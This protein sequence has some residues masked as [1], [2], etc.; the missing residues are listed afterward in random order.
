MFFI[1]SPLWDQAVVNYNTQ[2]E[3]ILDEVDAALNTVKE[4]ANYIAYS[5]DI[6][7]KMNAYLQTPSDAAVRFDLETV[8]YNTKNLKQGIEAVVLEMEGGDRVT[9]ILDLAKEE[10]E[11]LVSDWYARI[12]ENSYSGGFS[13]G[14]SIVKNSVPVKLIAYSKSYRMKNRKFTLTVLCG[15]KIFWEEL[16]ATIMMNL[17]NSIG[18]CGMEKRFLRGNRRGLISS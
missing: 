10:E 1:I 5:E 9:S 7:K 14:I 6:M 4:Y 17:R 11:L 18:V 13:K 16:C 2:N 15:M 8:L 3:Y 12:R